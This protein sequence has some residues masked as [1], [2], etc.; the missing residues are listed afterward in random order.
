[1]IDAQV[2]GSK[3]VFSRM[4]V[5]PNIGN[6]INGQRFEAVF[7]ILPKQTKPRLSPSSSKAS[8][9]PALR[10]AQFIDGIHPTAQ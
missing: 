2:S 8:A 10:D 7:A 4:M 1:L 9:A 6:A 5:P 3:I